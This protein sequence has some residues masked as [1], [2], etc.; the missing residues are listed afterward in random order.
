MPSTTR[1]SYYNDRNYE[2]NIRKMKEDFIEAIRAVPPGGV[3]VLPKD[4]LG[5]GLAELSKRAPK[6]A[7]WLKEMSEMLNFFATEPYN[8][9]GVM[10]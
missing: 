7:A 8:E 4:G 10:V 3:L 2:D 5:T 6:T 1:S 9:A